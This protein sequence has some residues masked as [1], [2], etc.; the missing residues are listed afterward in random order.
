VEGCEYVLH[1]ASPLPIPYS[2]NE[3]KIIQPAIAGTRFVAEAAIRHKVKRLVVTSSCITIVASMPNGSYNDDDWADVTKTSHYAKSKIL[4]EKALW[5]LYKAQDP[6]HKTE[7][8]AIMP[9]LLLG[10]TVN[11]NVG[12]L[13]YSE[14]ITAAFIDGSYPGIP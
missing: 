11:D 10:P 14:E 4:A 3:E 8:V 7:V 2:E 5:E 13:S 12:E 1:T 9:S 6:N